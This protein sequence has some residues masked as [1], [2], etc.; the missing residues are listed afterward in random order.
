M[1][2]LQAFQ[3]QLTTDFIKKLGWFHHICQGYACIS[4]I[5]QMM[6]FTE[7]DEAPEQVYTE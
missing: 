7:T 2:I 1:Y 4:S 6:N 3:Q 5:S